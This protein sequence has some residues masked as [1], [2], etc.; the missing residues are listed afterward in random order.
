[1]EPFDT[2]LAA[3]QLLAAITC[4]ILSN[5]IRYCSSRYNKTG[6]SCCVNFTSFY[7]LAKFLVL[8]IFLFLFTTVPVL[9]NKSNTVLSKGSELKYPVIII[10]FHKKTCLSGLL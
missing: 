2:Y 4:N 10:N 7:E 1:M 8:T 3:L 6:L 5:S 9:R